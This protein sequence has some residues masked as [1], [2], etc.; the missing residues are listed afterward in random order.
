[1]RQM[2]LSFEPGLTA[3]FRS[4]REVTAHSVYSSRRGL[5]AVAA[6]LDMSPSELTKRLNAGSAEPRPM[7]VD[8]LEAILGSTGDMS[9][10][11]WLIEKFL[12]DPDAVRQQATAQ[13]AAL[14]PALIELAKDAG[15][16]NV[17]A[18]QARR[19]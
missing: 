11:Y 17:T 2:S 16:G 14:L 13:I 1:M 15:V 3:R 10:V 5:S 9:P 19:S 8:D 4:L 18:L 7:R 12:R 6:D